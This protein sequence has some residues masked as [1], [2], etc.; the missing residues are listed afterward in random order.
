MPGTSNEVPGFLARA[1][2]ERLQMNDYIRLQVLLPLGEAWARFATNP[3][4]LAV[5]HASNMT[6]HLI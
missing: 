6:K 2:I 1:T 5:I 3:S 4:F